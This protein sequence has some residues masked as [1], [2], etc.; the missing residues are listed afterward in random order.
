[1]TVADL[2]R[3]GVVT[4]SPATTASELARQMRN[5][6]VGS[7]VVIDDAVRPTGIVTD[8]DITVG[9]T[10]AGRDPDTVLAGDVMTPDPATV[11]VD[12]GVTELCDA[13]REASVRRMPV[14]EDGGELAG[15]VTLDDIS[16]LLAREQNDLAG[17]I[18]AESPAY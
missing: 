12:A 4:A 17:V 14:V 16:V 15:I 11:H 8:R 3:D 1:M 18:E 7:V 5:E 6:R 2:M 10:A 13:L 9:A